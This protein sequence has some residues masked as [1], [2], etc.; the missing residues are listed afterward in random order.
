MF[1]RTLRAASDAQTHSLIS[2][3]TGS[4]REQDNIS[5]FAYSSLIAPFK[6]EIHKKSEPASRT[7]LFN[8]LTSIQFTATFST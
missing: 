8:K 4:L 2:S 6:N 7:S 3:K 5:L 1:K